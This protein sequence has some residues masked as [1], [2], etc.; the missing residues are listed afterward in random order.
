MRNKIPDIYPQTTDECLKIFESIT[1]E[2]V[3]FPVLYLIY[4]YSVTKKWS[5]FLR[6]PIKFSN[7]D[8]NCDTPLQA[9]HQMF[10]FLKS[11]PEYLT[12]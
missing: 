10:D 2:C 6:N 12:Q 3:G 5:V 7:P 4:D 9:C 8:I 11:N 1:Y